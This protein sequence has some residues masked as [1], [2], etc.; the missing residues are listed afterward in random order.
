L[1]AVANQVGELEDQAGVVGRDAQKLAFLV[2]EMGG[3]GHP[4]AVMD[5][6]VGGAGE[7]ALG[8]GLEDE[9]EE[10]QCL[11]VAEDVAQAV[12]E[13]HGRSGG[14]LDRLVDQAGAAKLEEAAMAGFGFGGPGE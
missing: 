12:A 9:A 7:Q 1:Q 5:Q 8:R 10:H 14:G 13:M 6:R 2:V 4:D 3:Q 11:R